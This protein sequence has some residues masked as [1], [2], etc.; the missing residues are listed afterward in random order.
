LV[1]VP[2]E[3]GPVF[4][5]KYLAKRAV[6]S[7][8]EKDAEVHTFRAAEVFYA[9]VGLCSK[10]ARREHKGFD[11]AWLLARIARRFRILKCEGYPFA[12]LPRVTN[13]GVGMVAEPR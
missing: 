5:G 4:L 11:Y 3:K 10:V 9:T 7:L 6:P 2:V 8:A 1:T 12:W 13:F